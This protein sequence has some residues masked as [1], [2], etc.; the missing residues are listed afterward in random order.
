MRLERLAEPHVVG[1]DAARARLREALEERDAFALVGAQLT[2]RRR[3]REAAASASRARLRRALDEL[4]RIR[5]VTCRA[6]FGAAAVRA[7]ASAPARDA[8]EG[9]RRASPPPW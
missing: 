3:L 1:E 9:L 7:A 6:V 4:R 5:H 8:R 2:A